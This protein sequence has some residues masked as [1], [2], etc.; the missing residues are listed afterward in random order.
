MEDENS[1]NSFQDQ[2]FHES[3]FTSLSQLCS[4]KNNT[5]PPSK[6]IPTC[7]NL[8]L[9]SSLSSVDESPASSSHRNDYGES[10]LSTSTSFTQKTSSTTD[11][12]F[13]YYSSL[14]PSDSKIVLS[15]NEQIVR[16]IERCLIFFQKSL[17]LG[18]R[19]TLYLPGYLYAQL[20][21]NS[22]T[23]S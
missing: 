4:S 2:S 5:P 23:L 9:S 21:L 3:T 15:K 22:T 20:F 8:R 13:S 6:T 16:K 17:V 11:S 12:G 18:P 7:C 10:V 1:S 14:E 19:P